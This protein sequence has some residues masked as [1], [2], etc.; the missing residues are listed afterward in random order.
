MRHRLGYNKLNRNTGHRRSMLRN[1]ATSLVLNER[2]NT[3]LPKA[4]E[5]RRIVEKLVTLGKRGDL[6]ARRQTASYLYD[7]D[8]T[9]KVFS[10]LAERFK[11][12]PGGYLR[13]MRKGKRF[14][15]GAEQAIIEFVD[16]DTANENKAASESKK[17]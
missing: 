1:M 6:H 4:K 15:D 9:Q 3:T 5:I 10:D 14:G 2:I 7:A 17:N 12:R 8:A 11:D 13:I 16:L